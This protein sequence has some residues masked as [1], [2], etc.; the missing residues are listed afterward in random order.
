M[1]AKNARRK[2]RCA[3]KITYASIDAAMGHVRSLRDK[4]DR[5]HAYRCPFCGGF[6]VGHPPAKVRQS[7][8][9]KR[10][11]KESR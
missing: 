9:A 3:K 10:K 11:A 7:I 2:R 1:S 8:R 6:H 4:G 5:I